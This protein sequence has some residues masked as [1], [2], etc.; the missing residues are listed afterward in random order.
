V[1][2]LAFG[3]FIAT[4]VAAAVAA[5][6][7]SRE[8]DVVDDPDADEVRLAAIF[9]PLSFRSTAAAFRGGTL[10]CWF[11]GGVLDLREAVPDPAGMHLDVRAIF[12]GGQIVVPPSWRVTTSVVGLGG[13]GDSR[14][15]GGHV[16]DA[17]DAPELTIEGVALFG[18]FGVTSEFS[19][20]EARGLD[21]A[22]ARYRA[23]RGSEPGTEPA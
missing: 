12:G 19:E 10:D 14:P 9:G 5:R 21:E 20:T 17:P 15:T 16:P 4:A 1:I 7:A 22:V 8:I 6:A 13:A 18:G 2:A 3:A 23:R 11:G